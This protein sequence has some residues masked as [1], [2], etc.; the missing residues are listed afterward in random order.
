MLGFRLLIALVPLDRIAINL[1]V[2]MI[3]ALVVNI[4]E[5]KEQGRRMAITERAR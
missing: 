1:V 3:S 5:S 4:K 2:V